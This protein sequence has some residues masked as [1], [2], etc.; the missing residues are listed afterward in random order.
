MKWLDNLVDEW[1]QEKG[2][3]YIHSEYLGTTIAGREIIAYR[4]LFNAVMLSII[5]TMLIAA[6]VQS[7][8]WAD[9]Y[10]Q[11]A[12]GAYTGISQPYS[13]TYNPPYPEVLN[14]SKKQEKA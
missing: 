12:N 6:R 11:F 1:K 7:G 10:K 3:K 14:S 4:L 8:S 2:K 13:P 5:P 9:V